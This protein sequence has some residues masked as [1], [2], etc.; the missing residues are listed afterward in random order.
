M[1]L[2]WN[3]QLHVDC[4]LTWYQIAGMPIPQK[5]GFVRTNSWS[6]ST[7]K[8]DIAYY[9]PSQIQPLGIRGIVMTITTTLYLVCLNNVSTKQQENLRAMV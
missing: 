7:I 9:D 2:T 5:V 1:V 3:L 4:I 6:V 8:T